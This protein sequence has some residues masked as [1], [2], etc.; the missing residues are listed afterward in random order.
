MKYSA[1]LLVFFSNCLQ[2]VE[3]NALQTMATQEVAKELSAVPES[4][5]ALLLGGVFWFI[6]LRKRNA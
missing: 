6:L 2:A 1:P 5:I 4:S 3:E